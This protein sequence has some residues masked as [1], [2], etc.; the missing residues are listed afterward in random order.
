[1]PMIFGHCGETFREN[2]F[3][4]GFRQSSGRG[5]WGS[6]GGVERD[7]SLS[8]L[9]PGCWNFGRESGENSFNV[10]C[11]I[12]ISN[13]S[14]QRALQLDSNSFNLSTVTRAIYF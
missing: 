2:M 1:M 4:C 10:I 8:V 3:N 5:V 14:K 7:I 13:D 11:S 6:R 9:E 12:P